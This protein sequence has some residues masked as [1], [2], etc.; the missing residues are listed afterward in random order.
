MNTCSRRGDCPLKCWR[1]LS[2]WIFNV[3]KTF[4]LRNSIVMNSLMLLSDYLDSENLCVQELQLYAI[5][6]IECSA[7]LGEYYPPDREDFVYVCDGAYTSEQVGEA[8]ENLT[9]HREGIVQ[10]VT[11]V[12]VLHRL[13]LDNNEDYS[14]AKIIATLCALMY[15]SFLT[16]PSE[17]LTE[18]CLNLSRNK[19]LSLLE[20]QISFSLYSL[21]GVY[22]IELKLDSREREV[23]A[24]FSKRSGHGKTKT[25]VSRKIIAINTS[26]GDYAEKE[27]LADTESRIYHVTSSSG[28]FV[29]KKL[30][31]MFD[32]LIQEFLRE[33]S[34]LA[35]YKHENIIGLK[36]F[37]LT[38]TKNTLGTE[39]G[40]VLSSLIHRKD[41]VGFMTWESTYLQGV[42]V[43][44]LIENSQN[45]ADGIVRGVQYLH[46]VGVLHNDIKPQNIVIVEGVAKIIDFGIST[47]MVL[48]RK[49]Y[50]KFPTLIQTSWYRCPELL[51]LRNSDEDPVIPERMAEFKGYNFGPDIWATGVVLLEIE[52]GIHPF[53]DVRLTKRKCSNHHC[54]RILQNIALVLGNSCEESKW[55]PLLCI[56]DLEK[57][58]RILGMLEYDPEKRV[59]V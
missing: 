46:S 22:T 5:A 12:D 48:S 15:P 49:D 11:S 45:I 9:R 34:I 32:N 29:V 33:L 3:C 17:E 54:V 40:R 13:E 41:T 44:S 31:D 36:G 16:V 56:R 27:R 52:T 7:L 30:G 20:E 42:K 2:L 19:Q 10:F 51:S 23:L 38:K 1:K 58:K 4:R 57:R 35:T 53:S 50:R 25:K 55:C 14:T 47:T 37:S 26:L 59:L 21:N 39:F 43:E 18:A 24:S 28:E 6:A 8:I